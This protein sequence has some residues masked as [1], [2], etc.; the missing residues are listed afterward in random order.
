MMAQGIRRR[1]AQPYQGCIIPIM[2]TS[3]PHWAFLVLDKTSFDIP[4]LIHLPTAAGYVSHGPGKRSLAPLLFKHLRRG[5]ILSPAS[6]SCNAPLQRR[7][8]TISQSAQTT[9][10]DNRCTRLAPFPKFPK[11]PVSSLPEEAESSSTAIA[12]KL[13]RKK[14]TLVIR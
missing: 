13:G 12:Q 14:V 1:C 8:S 6:A 10:V 9:A 2:G 5:K 3:I 7:T 11:F 4:R